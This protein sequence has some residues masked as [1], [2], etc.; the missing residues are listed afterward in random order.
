L[1]HEVVVANP[2]KVRLISESRRK[3]DR[4]DARWLSKLARADVD[5]LHPVTH[6]TAEMQAALAVLRARAALVKAR[7]ELV[8][9]CRGAVKSW[10]ARLPKCSTKGF[11]QRALAAV[12]EP[13]REAVVPLLAQ[14]E[15]MSLE[16]ARYDE[17]VERLSVEQFPES[18]RL[19]Q[20]HGVGA[21]VGLTFLLTLQ[22]PEHFRRARQVGAY[23]GLAP[24]HRDSGQTRRAGRITKEGD[25]AL[26]SLLVQ[27]AH[28]IL[29]PLGHDCD[30]RRFGERLLA[31]GGP[32][33]KRK[34]VVAVAR[35][36]AVVLHRLWETGE[37]YRPFSEKPSLKGTTSPKEVSPLAA[38]AS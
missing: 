33:A 1:G 16:I 12:P 8:L 18:A 29:G 19:R 6:R 26:R 21:N 3:S 24:G 10:G 25:R 30:L 7:T 4:I 9:H 13:L 32:G 36:L 17:R 37:T 23:V 15:A 28:Y 27:S 35:K 22:S 38:Q 20:I 11:S 5:L 34:A 14:I 2:R 31:R